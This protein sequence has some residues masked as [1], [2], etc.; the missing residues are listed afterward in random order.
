[1]HLSFGWRRISIMKL[2]KRHSTHRYL[3]FIGF[4]LLFVS[5]SDIYSEEDLQK[6]KSNIKHNVQSYS[7]PAVVFQLLIKFFQTFISTQDGPTCPF[8]PTCSA[9]GKKAIQK[10]GILKGVFISSERIIRCNYEAKGGL[11][12]VP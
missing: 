1:M 10:H 5:L 7:A 8:R 3:L 6:N 9:Y 2:R 12:P 4:F 11:D